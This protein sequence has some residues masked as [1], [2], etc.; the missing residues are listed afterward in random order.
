MFGQC[1]SP[2]V[3]GR[4]LTPPTRHSLGRPLPYQLAD[5]TQTHPKVDC[6]FTLQP[7]GFRDYRELANLSIGYARL[8]GW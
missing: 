1:L 8:W 4:A 3:G 7:Y 2:N 5:G 6:S